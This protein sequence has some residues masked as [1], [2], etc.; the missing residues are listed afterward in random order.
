MMRGMND[1]PLLVVVS[2]VRFRAGGVAIVE[3]KF[4]LPGLDDS[5]RT[6]ATVRLERQD[7]MP[8]DA[9][10]VLSRPLVHPFPRIR[11]GLVCVHPQASKAEVPAGTKVWLIS[12][13]RA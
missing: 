13:P 10:A 2:V 1:E 5:M 8:L 3:P 7:G 12:D 4:E 6:K 9:D 11:P